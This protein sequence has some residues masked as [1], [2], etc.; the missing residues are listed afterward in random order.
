MHSP[1][2]D[3]VWV[4][5]CVGV[6]GFGRSRTA[7]LTLALVCVAIIFLAGGASAQGEQPMN[8]VID[9]MPPGYYLR[10]YDDCGASGRQPHVD[11]TDCYFFTFSTKDTNADQKSRSAVFSYKEIRVNYDD[12]DP[13][14]S[15][16]LALTYAT[17]QVY[18]R[19]QSLEAD[20]V[21][22]HG[23]MALPKGKAI[24]VLVKVPQ[25]VTQDGKMALKIKIHGEVNATA[26][27]IE[28]WANAPG[29]T[30]QFG[31]V[32]ALPD[33]LAGRISD[34]AYKGVD[35][36]PVRLVRPSDSTT[37]A[38]VQTTMNG[39]FAFPKSN[40]ENIIPKEDLV[41]MADYEGQEISKKIPI[42]DQLFE[43]VRY[44]PIPVKVAGLKSNAVSLDGI[45]RIDP[46]PADGVRE[47]DLSG[48]GW[49]AFRV[50]GQWAEQGFDI[51][52]EQHAALSHEFTV[53][54]E[55][56]GY[57]I[58]LRFD[59]IHGGTNYW[60]NGKPLGYSENLFTPVEW[61]I[62]DFV[63]V[64]DSNRLDLDMVVATTSE[65]LSCSS[66]YTGHSIGGIDRAVRIYALPALQVSTLHLN[67][68]LDKAYRDGELQISL[69][70]DSPAQEKGIEVAV[71]LYGADGKSVEHSAPKTAVDDLKPGANT[72]NI[73]SRVANPLK[74]NAEQPNLYKLVLELKKGGKSLERIERS[75]GFRTIE[76]KNRQLYVNGAQVK[77]AGVCHHEIDPQTG[78]ADTMRHAEADVKAFKSG[79]LNYVRTS[80]YPCTQ[81]FLD[82]ADKYG[83]Y[84]ESEA[85]F[86]W[87]G[88]ADDLTDVKEVL[89]PTSAMVDYNHPH[90]SVIIWSL[91]N[92]S[93]WNVLFENSNKLIKQLDPTRPTTIEEARPVEAPVTCDITNRHY[94]KLPYDVY[95]DDPRPFLHG[96]CFFLVYHERTDVRIDPGLRELW[97]MGSADPTSDH[98]RRIIENR[99]KGGFLCGIEPGAWS[100]I[101]HSKRVIGSEIWSGVD[102]ISYLPSGKVES[103]EAG[104]AY[105]GLIDGWRRVKPELAL[106][107][108]VFSPVWFPVR[109]L[110]YK[111]GQASVQ[112]PVDNRYSF[113]NLS[114]CKFVWELNGE[115]GEATINVGPG[116]K[117][118]INIPVPAGT[119]EG[120]TLLVRVTNGGGEIVNASL[121]LG[122]RKPAVLPKPH[123]GAP[124]WNDDGK[125]II[126]QGKG[127]SFVL[128]R[129]KGDFDAANPAHKSPLVSFPALHV[130]RHDFGDLNRDKPPY[131]VYP[132]AKTRIVEGV[133][134]T[135]KA[136][137]LE[138]TVKDH[139]D[140]F[141]GSVRW[142]IDNDGVGE[143]SY[144]Y[145]YTGGATAPAS[146]S[147]A[148]AP[149]TGDDLDTREIG[150]M[151]LLRP[152]YDT[153]KWK[154]W[155]EWGVFP[156][157]C[158]CRTEGVAKAKRDK[159]WPEQPAN[160]K[161][162]WPWSQDQT[163]LGTN[164]FRGIKF[165]IYEASL[166]APDGSGVRVNA[167]A[168]A[169]FRACLDGKGVKMHILS[170]CPLS[171]ETL[172]S[173]E[174]LMGKYAV[175]LVSGR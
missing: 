42:A 2:S 100:Y 109:Q 160:V 16:V 119:P 159:K 156:K 124:K 73:T 169:H 153:L 111:P 33:G 102:D 92:E 12:L 82:A 112:V 9:T 144:D 5:G 7:F 79:N 174:K 115:K 8:Y 120:S 59:A 164:D 130:T 1:G 34:V 43:P 95:K 175:R 85:P 157:D 129:A 148:V 27:I 3:G 25:S 110:V 54:K 105:W 138:I 51:P 88:R 140:G 36:I 86:C 108:F 31:A 37:L 118:E 21:E 66:D 40:F 64:G 77:L 58:F 127:F 167:A 96:E 52:K 161:P 166:T 49:A 22:L 17:D 39:D 29:P 123:S 11:M 30:L 163:E 56:A 162:L 18:K 116:S 132:D 154:R 117:G 94:Q 173:G 13:K 81:E 101:Y 60:L 47:K 35:G 128:D 121:A 151:T 149:R 170:E 142:L 84:V 50:P 172:K 63:K 171:Q 55:W 133:T 137:G 68:G 134:V 104:N 72:V 48:K 76:V 24:R 126:V 53:P 98:S 45:W 57:R 143:I 155:S 41:I 4:Y 146:G 113:T 89:V 99:V 28:L 135:E 168:D 106:S 150:L 62:T 136:E 93:T 152:E 46:K 15:Y 165:N 69:G 26:S 6:C 65:R 141:A 131:A 145:T 67:A 32:S 83:L 147:G 103:S 71:G 10:A 87:V 91:A 20:G 61:E 97:A 38:A 158:I 107:K 78:R 80:H 14:L 44:R 139:Y 90:P 74:W 70:L 122:K 19:V 114:E 125:T 23:P 75:I